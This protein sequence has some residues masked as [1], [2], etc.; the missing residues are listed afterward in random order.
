MAEEVC[1]SCL[2]KKNCQKLVNTHKNPIVGCTAYKNEDDVVSKA[3]Y[4]QVKWERD[5]AMEQLKEAGIPFGGKADVAAMRHGKWLPTNTPSYFGG[6]I[7]KC[8]ECGAKDG[9]HSSI[10]GRYCWRCGVK[11]NTQ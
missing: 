5:V 11:M 9:D 1:S 2:Y 3:A 8:S 10:L 4:E 6:I 7:Y